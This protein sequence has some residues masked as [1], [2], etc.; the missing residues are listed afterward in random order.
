VLS[1][2]RAADEIIKELKVKKPKIK[3]ITKKK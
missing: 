2:E 1:G 3:K